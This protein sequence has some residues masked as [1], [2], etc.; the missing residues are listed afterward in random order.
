MSKVFA[1]KGI[2]TQDHFLVGTEWSYGAK[3]IVMMH[4]EGF[5]CSCQK[6]PRFPCK[7]ITNVKLRLYGTF[8]GH[9][10]Q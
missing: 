5:S 4:N 8:D 1:T 10:A 9:Y 6:K 2:V 7:H 3:G